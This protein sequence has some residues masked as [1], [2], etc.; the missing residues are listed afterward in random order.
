MG[1]YTTQQGKDFFTNE[2]SLEIWR[3]NYRDKV[4]YLEGYIDRQ[5]D[6]IFASESA[7]MKISLRDSLITKR[8]CFGGRVGANVGTDIKNVHAFNC[9]A[10][11]R[12]VKP[13]DSIKNIFSDLHNA[14]EILKTEG[15]VGFNFNHI[16]PKGTLIKGI[17]STTPGVIHFMRIYDAS[18]DVITKG[19]SGDKF[20]IRK[21]DNVKSKTRKGAQM[22]MLSICHPDVLDY[23]EAK[24]IPNFL[25]KF[26]MS[27]A[28]TNEFMNAV[29]KDLDW[30]LWF[31]DVHFEKYDEEWAGD[32]EEWAAKGYPKVVYK[33]LPAKEIWALLLRN[34]Y[35][36]NEPGIYF[37][38]NAN[39]YNNLI[40]YQKITGTNPCG[41]ISMLADAGVVEINGVLYEHLGDICNLGTLNLVSYWKGDYF[42]MDLFTRDVHLLVRALDNLIDISAYPLEG[43]KTAAKLRRK[44][45]CGL[46]GYGSLMFMMGFRYGSPEAN[47]FAR[48]LMH[49]Y[50]N[51]AYTASALIAKEKG[52]FLL[53]D[54]EKVMSNGF[55]ANS[56]ILTD[57]TKELIAAYGLRNSQM[58]TAAPNGNTGVLMG[59]VSGGVE[60]VFEK[61][62]IRWVT[63]SHKVQE[64]LGD[65]P[66]PAF[67]K[68]EWFETDYFKFAMKGDEEVLMSVDGEYM[69]D[70]NRGLIKAVE[71]EDYGWA[72]V[73]ANYTPEQID[74]LAERGVFACSMDLSIEEHVEP[75]IIFSQA[76]DNSISKTI[77]I[78]NDAP[79]EDFDR[80][81]RRLW[82]EGVRG[83][84]T[85]RAGTMTAV[86]ETKGDKAQIEKAQDDFYAVW[87]GHDCAEV[88]E[89]VSLPDEYP[90]QGHVIKSE[91]KKFYVHVAFK[92]RAQTKPFALFVHTN[93]KESD[94]VTYRVLE[95]LEDLA[96]K[97]GVPVEH[98][99]K[100]R[101]KCAGQNNINKL[102]RTISLLLRHNVGIELIV[103][104]LDHIQEI[105]IS[106][107]VFRIKKF[108]S[109]YIPNK[110]LA[111][112]CPECGAPL[113][114]NEGCKRCS[115]CSFT[116]C[117]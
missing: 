31:P 37:I 109:R 101:S 74:E 108:L 97:V 112:T 52:S 41:E 10:A 24:K 91:G 25:T 44:I 56:G 102:A 81:Y 116:F 70:R 21:G 59:I 7:A 45:G 30:D 38:D 12:S 36:R 84:T 9:Y 51:E 33:T 50:A 106:S 26:N 96:S 42:D 5:V 73:K 46:M 114:Y 64:E 63:V 71:C 103:E 78:A 49:H 83:C 90:A 47:E 17:G 1:Y 89:S 3:D 53:F 111:E 39:R 40:H 11:Q 82:R 80:L 85:Y 22:S 62:F 110:E 16:R 32:F 100:N 86:L 27:V 29:E 92:D 107:F 66:Y 95:E 69:I 113:M 34:T 8:I 14:A 6:T 68:Q 87:E 58:L 19:N 115:E 77:N 65:K 88:F 43:L 20:Q 57:E 15:G 76:I 23:I 4:E 54:A 79:F 105:P 61:E 93:N 75:F 2:L 13:F 28:V 67:D 18:A 94:I 48:V 72:W 99:D 55:I 60:P 35:N 98:I 117:G 104:A